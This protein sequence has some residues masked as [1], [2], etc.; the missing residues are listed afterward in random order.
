MHVGGKMGN[1]VPPAC[2]FTIPLSPPDLPKPPAPALVPHTALLMSLI[3][4]S[5]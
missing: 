3:P 2:P 4:G 5:S 1:C